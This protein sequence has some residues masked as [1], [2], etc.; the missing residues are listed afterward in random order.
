M[1]ISVTDPVEFQD[2]FQ[3]LPALL[4]RV[5]YQAHT[6]EFPGDKHPTYVGFEIRLDGRNVYAAALCPENQLDRVNGT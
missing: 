4:Y 1:M 2:R 5:A 6:T 3:R